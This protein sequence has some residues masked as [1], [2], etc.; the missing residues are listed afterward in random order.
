MA[1]VEKIAA[2][3]RA[4]IEA[5]PASYS[6]EARKLDRALLDELDRLRE[7]LR[8]I[9]NHTSMLDELENCMEMRR[10]AA[11]ALSTQ[12]GERE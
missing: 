6:S 3:L 7:A 12:V 2:E 1:D 11:R 10:I 8:H 5:Y 9:A 4:R